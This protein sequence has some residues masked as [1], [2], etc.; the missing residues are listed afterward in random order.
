[1]SQCLGYFWTLW[2]QW[3]KEVAGIE[4][5]RSNWAAAERC[6]HSYAGGPTKGFPTE[7]FDVGWCCGAVGTLFTIT[8]AFLAVKYVLFRYPPLF[9]K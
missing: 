5:T 1:M 8:L 4:E 3:E 9:I 2:K 6:S 7:M